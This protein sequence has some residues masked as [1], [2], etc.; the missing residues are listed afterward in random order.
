[1]NIMQDK[2]GFM[3][4]TT[5]DGLA[6]FDGADFYSYKVKK[7]DN[8]GM[9]SDRFDG[10]WLDKYGY[11]WANS[12][13][14]EMYRFN[15]RTENFQSIKSIPALKSFVAHGIKMMPSGKKWLLN[16]DFGA[17]CFKDTAF[18]P[19]VL[20]KSN[21]GLPQN[22][23]N[24]VAEDQHNNSWLLTS[25]GIV[26]LSANLAPSHRYFTSSN[27]NVHKS[28]YCALPVGNQ[29]W[30][31]ADSGCIY[32]YDDLLKKFEIRKTGTTAHIK[33]I[34]NIDADNLLI[35]SAHNDF[36]VF[37]R[38]T[39]QF[40]A[41]Q[42]SALRPTTFTKINSCYIDRSKNIWL[43]TDE[44]GVSKFSFATR[45]FKHFDFKLPDIEAGPAGPRFFIW[46]DRKNRVW[47]Q[48]VGG[49]LGV[50]DPITDDLK[51]FDIPYYDHKLSMILHAGYSDR[52]GDLWVSTR[53]GGL[54]KIL[55]NDSE[56][57]S[58][59]VDPDTNSVPNNDVRSILEDHLHRVWIATKAG[60]IFIYSSA[61]KNLGELNHPGNISTSQPIT[62]FT[63]AFTED[64]ANQVWIGTK[65]KGL[66]RLTPAGGNFNTYKVTHFGHDAAN[67]YSLSDD[68]VYSIFV[69][70]SQHIWVT[71]YGGGLNLMDNH[72][73]GRFYN[74]YNVLK[75][76]P[77]NVGKRTRIVSGDN[78][79]N[80]YIGT[81]LGLLVTHPNYEHPEQM[82]FRHFERS[83]AKGSIGANDIY[84]VH[85]SKS[86]DTYIASF[87]GG[88]N[89]VQKRDKQGLPLSFVTYN[90][91]NGLSSD[92]LQ[93][94]QEDNSGKLWL[95]TENSVSRFDPKEKSFETYYDLSRLIRGEVFSEGGDT[96]TD[97]GV[98]LLGYS[99]G[100][101][102]IDPD[103]LSPETFNPYMALTNLRIANKDVTV[104]DTSA[105][106]QQIDELS[107]FKLDHRQNF[108]SFEFAA[109]DFK[110]TDRIN[111]AYRL[112]G[113]D[114][115]W[116][117]TKQRE[118]SY[119]NL[120]PGKYVFRVRSTNGH[121]KW[122]N[123]EHRI[124]M[125]IVPAFW[126]TGWAWA[127]YILASGLLIFLGL[128]WIY[129]YYRLKDRLLLEQEQ[130][131]MKNNFFTDVSHEIRTP[132]TMI[133]SPLERLLDE[134][135]FTPKATEHLQLIHKNATRML[136]LVNQ[137]LDLRKMESQ[138]L[139]IREVKLFDAVAD[140]INSFKPIAAL[141]GVDLQ[142]E[143]RTPGLSIW[144]DQDGFEKMIYN[145]VSNALKHTSR[146]DKVKAEIFM[147]DDHPVVRICDSGRG[148]NKEL[149]QKLFSR[150]L[151]HNPNKSQPSTGI[152]LSI[153]KE[154]A[155]RHHARIVV[156]STE[157]V[158]STFT[159]FFEP[160]N[161]HFSDD[162]NVVILKND[163]S[164]SGNNT[165]EEFS[166][167]ETETQ[168]LAAS[169]TILVI[170]DDEDLRNYLVDTL[171]SLYNVLSAPNAE[172]GFEIAV[173]QTPDF[174]LSDMMMPGMGGLGLL[175]KLRTTATTSHIPLV[176]LT[177]RTDE[178]TELTAYDYGAEAFMTKPFS[179]KVLR[180]R[181][182][183]IL[184]QRQRLYRS[185]SER[186]TEVAE[187]VEPNT[188]SIPAPPV[189][190]AP[191]LTKLDE[192]F[193]KKIR[194][195]IDNHIAEADYTVEDLIATMPMSRTV[196][197]KKLKSLTGQSPVEF[198]R[199]VK[200]HHAA[201]LMETENYA[202]KEI[203]HMV[204]IT[205]TKYF[206]QRFKEVM[207][208]M[209]SEYKARFK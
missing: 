3:W 60:K 186:T 107:N 197:V 70:P 175:K 26:T 27:S 130:A 75:G 199:Y 143:E 78:Y 92:L 160:G 59:S 72:I 45:K 94:I 196:L 140:I 198:M 77:M 142:V 31:G 112:D 132:L 154:I 146:G 69:D 21:K 104:G 98:M 33:D 144:V 126:Q 88:L 182:K 167:E 8:P 95:V 97:K 115:D 36:F 55:F 180:S 37:N 201:K 102:T 166:Q 93:Q 16:K 32:I 135:S 128:R 54:H 125:V 205:D 41:Y 67:T 176:F 151:S 82:Q 136:R 202:I 87:G 204:G 156:E 153:V 129:Y 80:I 209:P 66:Y 172:T 207:G 89:K 46:E 65:G 110:N 81:P 178:A 139:I 105:L 100:L 120:A 51:H 7:D 57:K 40:A 23:V 192:Q 119:S 123:N 118:A 148:M 183:T 91:N 189:E 103:K 73:D 208:E 200:I 50:Y 85:T 179:A 157:L 173:N 22:R 150:F 13:E 4:F 184:D 203:S 164:S 63:Y 134:E 6:K 14:G 17:I 106:P 24:A 47:M 206:A 15:P 96:Q 145:L 187:P 79:G 171:Q 10:M 193:L 185:F 111:Y 177:A 62:G 76:F 38:K 181:I 113:V 84:D 190:K 29:L 133:V 39:N 25:N 114:N 169:N 49:G 152:G 53:A 191:K 9:R 90:T 86:G 34:K 19:V 127:F 1:M 58:H 48:P 131:E 159:L 141:S 12:Y 155:D 137:V 71:T 195:E 56:F 122:I 194:I 124:S 161:T 170:E 83:P 108:V 138:L 116:V 61:G 174:I 168:Q 158:G 43:E 35:T 162:K 11:I 18:T 2:K 20:T 42:L 44:T 149:V 99:R 121:G 52:Q 5:W 117:Y 163:Q 188:I 28:F 74:P 101:I 30:I 147:E 64:V 165:L 109:L 68:R